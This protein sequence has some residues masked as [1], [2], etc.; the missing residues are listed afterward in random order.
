[1]AQHLEGDWLELATISGNTIMVLKAA[2]P[3]ARRLRLTV[4]AK[5]AR[6][7]YPQG[8]HPAQ[9]NAFL[10]S[11][12]EW[13]E[14]KLDELNLI[15]KPLPPLRVGYSTDIPLRGETVTLDWAEGPYPRI[16]PGDVGLTLVIPRPHSRA[17]PIARGLLASH[18]EAMMRRDVSRWL[19]GYVPQLGL[20]PT[21][22]KIRPM[23]SLW[24]S[25]DTRDRINL[26]LALAL[27][28]PAALRYVLVH[29]LCHLKVRSHAPRFWAQVENLFPDWREQRDWL[30]LNGATLK[31]ELDRLVGD[32][33]D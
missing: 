20:A 17:L 10:R 31:A 1:M 32:V 3:R 14:Q 18:L 27:A 25:L 4:T 29:E 7:S 16:E 26:D 28:P 5:G 22:L 30:R 12:A 21:A 33:A 24:G 23:K 13:L 2:H 11:H 19:A 9:V 15:L 6:V 8:T